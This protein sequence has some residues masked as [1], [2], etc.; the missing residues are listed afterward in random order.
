[1]SARTIPGSHPFQSHIGHHFDASSGAR[2][3]GFGPSS[4]S[5]EDRLLAVLDAELT[6]T[7]KWAAWCQDDARLEG[8][9]C[10]EDAV[11][12]WASR[13]DILSYRVVA[14][15][16]AIGSRRGG[17]D[18]EAAMAVVVLLA[19]GIARLA[20]TLRDVCEVDD[21]RATVWE[22]V[23]LAEPQ[24]GNLAARYLLQRAQQRLTRP[25]AGNVS[26]I[27]KVSLDQRLGWCGEDRDSSR[28][29]R[30]LV[31]AVPELEDPVSDL[32]DL[33]TWAREV[34]VIEPGE[35]DLIVELMAAANEGIGTE[36]AQRLI[37]ER[38]GVAM[39]TIRRR[40]DA[41]LARLRAAAPDYLAAIA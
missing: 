29:D 36:D 5:V 12:G 19:P 25:A 18:D 37:G 33:L 15:L 23:K 20:A 26:R 21:V 8:V 14:A 30:S 38:H 3:G 41:T 17:D 4:S 9:A 11:E 35:V 39:R 24:L 1:M 2:A 27:E 13:R 10:L 28:G 6:R 34:G 22:E 32:A 16:T 40:R 7:G 31:L